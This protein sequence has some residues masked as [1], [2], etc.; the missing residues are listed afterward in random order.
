MSHSCRGPVSPPS[1]HPIVPVLSRPQVRAAVFRRF[2]PSEVER[3]GP[4]LH[5][6]VRLGSPFFERVFCHVGVACAHPVYLPAVFDESVEDK[7]ERK[8][9]TQGRD[10]EKERK[11]RK[12]TTQGR[13][14][15]TVHRHHTGILRRG[16]CGASRHLP[17]GVCLFLS[18]FAVCRRFSLQPSCHPA[19]FH[20]SSRYTQSWSTWSAI[21]NRTCGAGELRSAPSGPDDWHRVTG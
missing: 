17:L 3:P 14:G 21:I 13:D 12:Q 10:G 4:P 5:S 16:E 18:L 11:E 19:V 15:R 2:P 8:Q 1:F 6:D 7:K 9:T 20:G